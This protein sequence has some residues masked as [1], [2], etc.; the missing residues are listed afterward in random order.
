[1]KSR[2]FVVSAVL[3]ATLI[4]STGSARAHV[5]DDGKSGPVMIN[6]KIGPAIEVYHSHTQFA[7]TLEGMY[8]VLVTKFGDLYVGLPLTFQFA[9]AG[10]FIEIPAAAQF[11]VRLPVKNLYIVTQLH[12]GYAVFIPSDNDTCLFGFCTTI[13]GGD[14]VHYGVITPQ[15]GLKYA[16]KGRGNVG[17]D[18][19]QLPIY[20]NSD[21]AALQYR[22]MFYGGVNF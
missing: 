18:I 9:G 16:I 13:K 11:D 20:F 6:L 15:L 3:L 1:M 22:I 7:M 10:T 12:I 14:A 17:I 21:G 2:S 5:L 19:F 4:L 8:A